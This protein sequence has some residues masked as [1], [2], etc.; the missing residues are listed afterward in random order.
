MEAETRLLLDITFLTA[1]AGICSIVLVKL[2]MPTIIGYLV[3]GIVLGPTMLPEVTVQYSTV[4]FLSNLGIVLLMFYIGMELNLREMRRIGSFTI[5]VVT[6]EMTMM[7]MVGY[8]VGMMLGLGPVTSIFLGAIISGTSTAVVVGVLHSLKMMGTQVAKA[9]V[10]ITVLEDIGQ[11]I[12]LT[13]AAPLLNGESPT[14]Q[15]TIGMVALIVLFVSII[16]VLG[17]LCIPKLLDWVGSRYSG[18]IL[19]LFAVALCFTSALI[20]SSIGLSIAIGAFVMGLIVSQSSYVSVIKSKVEPMKELFMAV[21]FISIG[22]QIDPALIIGG[23]PMALAIALMFIIGK[24]I[25]VSVACYINNMKMRSS[26]QVA[27]SLVAMGE[28]AFIITQ[29]AVEAGQVDRQFYSV[30]IGAALITM[31]VMPVLSK[32]SLRI[33]DLFDKLIPAPL[34]NSFHRVSMFKGDVCDRFDA[35]PETRRRARMEMLL[36]AVDLVVM[37]SLMLVINILAEE[38]DGFLSVLDGDVLP[39]LL[40]FTTILLLITPVVLNALLGIGRMADAI[41]GGGPG[42]AN[43]DHHEGTPRYRMVR[44]F[45][46]GFLMVTLALLFLPLL[47][48]IGGAHYLGLILIISTWLLMLYLTWKSYRRFSEGFKSRLDHGMV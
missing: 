34:S 29:L 11:V 24:V 48:A 35:A 5:I 37:I 2:K 12:I 46:Y 6:M 30:I 33:Y 1:V 41:T 8:L 17:A 40:T 20:S 38:G 31:I 45:G 28:F 9:A 16:I 43:G 32:N 7:V 23:L 14:I 21:F 25:S 19:L 15:S 42:W 36:I 26:F 18:E 44:N 3:A 13:L 4:F 47:A 27:V 39:M 22:L 10:G